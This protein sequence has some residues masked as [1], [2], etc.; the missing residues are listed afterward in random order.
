MKTPALT[1]SDFGGKFKNIKLHVTNEALALVNKSETMKELIRSYQEDIH[2]IEKPTP[3]HGV[4]NLSFSPLKNPLDGEA[5]IA[6]GFEYQTCARDF[7]FNYRNKPKEP[8]K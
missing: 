2:R 5:G 8:N 4:G 1:L 6:F 3:L 7:S